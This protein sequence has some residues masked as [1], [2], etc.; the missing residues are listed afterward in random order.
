MQELFQSLGI[1]WK[2]LLSQ[3]V[4]FLILLAV[5]TALLWR[6]LLKAMEER[7]KK[8]EFGVKLGEEAEKKLNEIDDLKKEKLI[9]ADLH[10]QSL[11][12]EAEKEAGARSNKMVEDAKVKG[13]S[14]LREATEAAELSKKESFLELEKESKEILRSAL[15]KIVNLN[16][17][18]IEAKLF[19][20]A[21]LEFQKK[22]EV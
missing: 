21:L 15:K 20:Q 12:R 7:K 13:D 14:L 9:E 5:L 11:I 19:D 10:S 3:G 2:L 22:N 8:I 1:N 6:P 18:E 4:N 17:K 16:P